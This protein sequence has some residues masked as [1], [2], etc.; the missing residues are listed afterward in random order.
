MVIPFN[1]YYSIVI[2]ILK[3]AM[4][5]AVIFGDWKVMIIIPCLIIILYGAHYVI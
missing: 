5:I 2:I 4:V 3:F 1:R